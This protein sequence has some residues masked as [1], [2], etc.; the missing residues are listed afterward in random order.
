MTDSLL[1]RDEEFNINKFLVYP[2]DDNLIVQT[3]AGITKISDKRMIDMILNWDVNAVQKI[4]KE[5]LVELFAEDAGEAIL[6]LENY[7]IIEQE[8]TNEIN[9]TGITIV[10]DE[11]YIG[12]LLYDRLACHYE[13]KL[14]I[15]IT[16]PDNIS[17][18]LMENQF[19]IYLQL[20]YDKKSVNKF[21]ELQERSENSVSI[22]GYTYSNNFYLDC[23]YNPT[24]KLPCHNCHLGH[25]QS[26]FYS[27]DEKELS[28]QMMIDLIYQES[29]HSF[30]RGIP[31]TP[32]QEMN[33]AC[34]ILNKVVGYL[35]N[36]NEMAMHPQD[37]NKSTMLNLESLKK[38]EGTAIYW[39]MCDCYE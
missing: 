38:S 24:W 17:S 26:S 10:S 16:S 33:I 7:K 12:S 2:I 5:F 19:I 27:G 28:Y 8:M 25:I 21:L 6:F 11:E 30:I 14:T 36:L 4:S 9:I 22:I 23:I 13:N 1:L 29:N 3:P 39:E 31:L 37:I 32:V 18:E 35:G 34:L 20:K 15:N